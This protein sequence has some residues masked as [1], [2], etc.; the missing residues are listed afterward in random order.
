MIQSGNACTECPSRAAER[1]VSVRDMLYHMLRSQ[2]RRSQHRHHSYH[3][4]QALTYG[5][6]ALVNGGLRSP[7][8]VV[9]LRPKAMSRPRE[10]V[11]F[12][13]ESSNHRAQ[14]SVNLLTEFYK[15]RGTLPT[16]W[17]LSHVRAVRSVY[18]E[19]GDPGGF[20]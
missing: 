4:V 13:Y 2:P 7:G 18:Q 14:G 3:T 20:R 16:R 5:R 9:N 17:G 19:I 10:C 1:I 11:L 6:G 15:P 12:L 8:G